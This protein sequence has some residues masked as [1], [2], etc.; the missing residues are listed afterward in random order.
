MSLSVRA[1]GGIHHDRRARLSRPYNAVVLA[2]V[3][4]TSMVATFDLYLFASSALH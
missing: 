2:L 4:I 1:A 3:V